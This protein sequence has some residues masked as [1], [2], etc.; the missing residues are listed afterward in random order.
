MAD[1]VGDSAAAVGR[2]AGAAPARSPVAVGGDALETDDDAR[3]E[4]AGAAELGAADAEAAAGSAGAL[5][6]PYM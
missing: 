3:V 1:G 2:G 6:A 4:V 5:P